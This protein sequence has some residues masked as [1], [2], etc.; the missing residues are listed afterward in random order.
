[1]RELRANELPAA[2]RVLARGMRDNP[3]NVQAMGGDQ[4]TRLRR[5]HGMLAAALPMIMRKAALLGAFGHDE[6]VGVLGLLPPG[7]CRSTLGEK[8]GMI[9]SM[10]LA[11]GLGAL[12]RTAQWQGEWQK[13]DPAEPHWHLG[14][15]AVDPSLRGRGIGSAMM[16]A[17]CTR[18]DAVRAVGY[19][20]TDK[21]GNLRFYER[22]GFQTIAE[23]PVLGTLNW[24]MRRH[25]A[26]GEM[27]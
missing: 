24:F 14:P 5:L 16:A 26:P 3:V 11:M 2:V 20:E 27:P 23:A 19:L 8:V 15:V 17:Y 7:M 6:L 4:D 22:F 9:P 21:P 1:M 18:L 12:L 25:A 10:V 13:R